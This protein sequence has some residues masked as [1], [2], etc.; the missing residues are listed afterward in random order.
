MFGAHDP[1]ERTESNKSKT[2]SVSFDATSTAAFPSQVCL[3]GRPATGA[4]L[5]SSGSNDLVAAGTEW[6]MV[7]GI[8]Q[9][10]G[11]MVSADL[12][13]AGPSTAASA[14]A[15]SI[16]FSATARWYGGN[17]VHV[18]SSATADKS[19]AAPTASHAADVAASRFLSDSATTATTN[20]RHAIK[21]YGT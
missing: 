15:S 4:A 6:S 7:V 21:T 1:E 18:V 5:F 17:H 12:R 2:F 14:S 16:W 13:R 8:F 9:R 10:E 20:A 11:R 19:S 3:S